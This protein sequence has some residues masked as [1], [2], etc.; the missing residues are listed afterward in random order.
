MTIGMT[1]PVTGS[2]KIKSIPWGI[3]EVHRSRALKNHG[4]PLERLYA[5]GGLSIVEIAR[6]I[7]D[8]GLDAVVSKSDAEKMLGVSDKEGGK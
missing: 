1:F 6:I 4:L 8:Q 7:G 3:L 2:D 5:L